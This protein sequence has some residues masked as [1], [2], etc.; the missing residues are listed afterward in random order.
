MQFRTWLS[1]AALLI[2]SGPLLADGHATLDC[3][4][5][6][7]TA[8]GDAFRAFNCI[9]AMDKDLE[10]ARATISELENKIAAMTA[11]SARMDALQADMAKMTQKFVPSV[12][13][14][15]ETKA[16]V[17]YYSAKGEKACPKG[18]VPYED[19]KDRFILG[20]GN[21][22]RAVGFKDGEKTVT[23]GI[24][25]MPSHDHATATA[26]L[27]QRSGAPIVIVDTGTSGAVKMPYGFD[28]ATG[29]DNNPSD[30]VINH[31]GGSQ[32]HNN[33]PPFIALYFCQK[34]GE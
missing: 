27:M 25:E 14:H 11:L 33:M 5:L 8:P 24:E 20:A 18:W 15:S 29:V 4:A 6:D 30:D 9:S 10:E 19:A 34:K 23:L 22:H 2:S 3:A 13:E 21:E 28:F 1:A 7:A 12:G 16:I 31:K 17:A 32:P 26:G